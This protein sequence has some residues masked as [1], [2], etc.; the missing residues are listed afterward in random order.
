M[1]RPDLIAEIA[2]IP[3]HRRFGRITGAMGMM[4]ETGGLPHRPG[5]G[6]QCTVLAQDGRRVACEVVGIRRA[7]RALR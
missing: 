6:R 4:L 3:E 1:S 2:L 7:G 5:V